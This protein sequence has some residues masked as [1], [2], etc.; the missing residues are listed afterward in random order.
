MSNFE[1]AFRFISGKRERTN[2]MT[3]F[4]RYLFF[5]I[6]ALSACQNQKPEGILTKAEMADL[7]LEVY[8]SE[9]IMGAAPVS[10]DSALKLFYPREKVILEKRGLTDSVLKVNYQYY[11]Q[12]PNEM[13]EILGAV[14]DS[15]TLREQRL[16]NKTK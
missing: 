15:L 11:L 14:V 2:G 4:L 5:G 12:R 16:L 3:T 8:L 9:A 13:D 7:L 10:R 6:L 1:A